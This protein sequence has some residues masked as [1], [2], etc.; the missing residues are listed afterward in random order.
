MSFFI[1][2]IKNYVIFGKNV[3]MCEYCKNKKEIIRKDEIISEFSWGWGN[4]EVKINREQATEYSLS[5]FI[6]RGYIRL[7]DAEDCCCL[8]HGEKVKITFCPFCG[9]KI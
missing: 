6:D 1:V 2:N 8:D 5:M 7:V 9:E 3:Y 4:Q